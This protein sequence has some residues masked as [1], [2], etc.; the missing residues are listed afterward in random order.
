MTT[1]YVHALTAD[2]SVESFT[3]TAASG[4]AAVSEISMRY[5]LAQRGPVRVFL[6]L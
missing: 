1:H 6:G 5:A 3:V 2:G 4:E